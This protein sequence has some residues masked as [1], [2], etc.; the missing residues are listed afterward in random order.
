VCVCVC[1][2]VCVEWILEL[3]WNESGIREIQGVRHGE[4][5]G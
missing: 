1:V 5:V 3:N 2:C 4:F